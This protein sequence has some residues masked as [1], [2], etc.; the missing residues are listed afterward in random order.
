ME[1]NKIIPIF[2]SKPLARGGSDPFLEHLRPLFAKARAVDLVVS[3]VRSS[4]LTAIKGPLLDARDRGV[5]IRVL[6]GDYLDITEVEALNLLMDWALDGRIRTYIYE[7][8]CDSFHPKA[9]IFHYNQGGSAFVGS[10]NLSHSALGSGIEWNYRID[11]EKDPEGFLFIN[12]AFEELLSNQCVKP[13][14]FQWLK[15]YRE[16]CTRTS[17][18]KIFRPPELIEPES[19]A[20]LPQPHFIQEQAL[21][22]LRETRKEG[23]Q[24]GLVVLA[25]GLGK[26]YLAAFDSMEFKRVLFV[27]HREEILHQSQSV[28]RKMRPGSFLGIFMG[29]EKNS[30]ADVLFASIQTLSKKQNLSLFEPGYFDYII[31]DEF[32]HACANTYRKL[33]AHFSPSFLLG[34]TATPERTDQSD[35]LVLCEN[36]LV[37]EKSLVAGITAGLLVPFS[38]YG[39]KDPVDYQNIPWR[40]GKF[41]PE[42][43]ENAVETQV[44]AE[45]ALSS[46]KKLKGTRTIA[47]CCSRHHSDFMARYFKE[48]GGYKTASVHS[49]A[50]SDPRAE[51]LLKLETGELDVIFAVD[52][53][54]EGLDVPDVDTVL[55]LRPTESSI[56]FL[57]QMGR[58]LRTAKDKE[59][60]TIIDFI[61]NHRSFL[62]K[63]RTLLSLGGGTMTLARS[64]ESVKKNTIE[65]PPGC[66]VT[67]EMGLID[68]MKEFLKIS[69]LE[70]IE[71]IYDEYRLIHGRRILAAEL[72]QAGL[73][74]NA[75]R[76]RYGGWFS[77]VG[78]R[79]DLMEKERYCLEKEPSWF[80][81]LEMMVMKNC[82]FFI[83]I[84]ALIEED[85][86]FVKI[87]LD[88]LALRAH[89]IL[90][91][92][93]LLQKDID[94][95][96]FPNPLIPEPQKW[97]TYWE[98]NLVHISSGMQ[99]NKLGRLFNYRDNLF[100]LNLN[101]P[102]EF[103]DEFT[104]MTQELIDYRLS[105]YE[106]KRV[107]SMPTDVE[108]TK[109]IIAKVITSGGKTI[110]PIIMLGN[111]KKRDILPFG[112]TD[113]LADGV[114]YR[115]RFVKKAINVMGVTGKEGNVLPEVLR[116]WFGPY[117]G[118]PGTSFH[119]RFR[120]EA[121]QWVMEPVKMDPESNVIY[122]PGRFRVP[123]FRDFRVACGAFVN[124]YYNE[125]CKN[126]D[127][128]EIESKRKSIDTAKYFVIIAEGTSMDGGA[129]PI[130]DGDR[131]LMEWITAISSSDVEGRI[132]LVE[133]TSNDE[134]SSFALKRI[135][136]K[137]NHW[138]LRSEEEGNR[139]DEPVV[140]KNIAPIARFVE[141]IDNKE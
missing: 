41:D 3:F 62:L 73:S 38:Y 127:I 109:E 48:K 31:I 134:T 129:N 8:G 1:T 54:N 79:G 23:Y 32:H 95:E 47:F 122:F 6:T 36:N 17:E 112:D 25:T 28:F 96:L 131:V 110:K 29:K 115:A 93:P 34:I 86:F 117:A 81:E 75:I 101:V 125:A 64:L 15:E 33:I 43:L 138:F 98:G 49:G 22:A 92:N 80:R 12:K 66:S 40:N 121:G 26:T 55:M 114:V 68:M 89:N 69:G 105:T 132:C 141:L 2:R 76:T 7:S 85:A 90:A 61:G 97:L 99:E 20:D 13:L 53:F 140:F 136:R 102:E 113:L 88:S 44:R 108:I 58:G 84:K 30:A 51:S 137:G 72:I 37:Y 103:R 59:R 107:I 14:D 70:A 124:G 39:I 94:P 135:V 5:P 106:K 119:V 133:K 104:A 83:T 74:F 77:F 35:L 65:L 52:I 46:W 27:A 82:F 19:P 91:R 60:L 42:M 123:F 71:T 4:G 126:A 116:K 78:S 118:S 16:R 87:P 120:N 50:G 63:P 9:Y 139:R 100:S 111:L 57:Q 130:S 21:S 18:K 128:L 67:Y 11:A 56:L 45:K 10:S 24:A